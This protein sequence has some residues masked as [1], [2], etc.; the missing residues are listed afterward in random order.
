M[1]NRSVSVSDTCPTST[2]EGVSRIHASDVPYVK[3]NYTSQVV[4]FDFLRL[5]RKEIENFFVILGHFS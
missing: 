1:T 4:C 2:R 3:K 5:I